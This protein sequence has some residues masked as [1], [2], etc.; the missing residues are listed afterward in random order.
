MSEELG[1]EPD[2]DEPKMNQ[3][4]DMVDDLANE[5]RRQAEHNSPITPNMIKQIEAIQSLIYRP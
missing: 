2:P 5:M 4:A 1:Y 3:L